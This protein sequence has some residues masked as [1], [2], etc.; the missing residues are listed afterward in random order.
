MI[1]AVQTYGNNKGEYQETNVPGTI[2]IAPGVRE[3]RDLTRSHEPDGLIPCSVQETSL[4]SVKWLRASRNDKEEGEEINLNGD[5]KK[6]EKSA[7][8]EG[9]QLTPLAPSAEKRSES[10]EFIKQSHPNLSDFEGLF[11]VIFQVFQEFSR[12]WETSRILSQEKS[13]SLNQDQVKSCSCRSTAMAVERPLGGR[14]LQ[15]YSCGFT[16]IAVATPSSL[17]NLQR[18]S[19]ETTAMV[20]DL[21][22]FLL[23]LGCFHGFNFGRRNIERS[24]REGGI[25][26]SFERKR[27]SKDTEEEAIRRS[28][29]AELDDIQ[30]LRKVSRQEYLKKREE[31]KL[32]ELRDDIEDE[33][34]L[35]EGVKLSEVKYRELR[36]KKEIYELVKKRSEEAD[37]VNEVW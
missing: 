2:P 17:R 28:N 22:S 8:G 24:K 23:G 3:G 6:L 20:V 31:N 32:E 1:I 27:C 18:S 36:Y 13:Q 4:T 34:Y 12:F 19:G 26:A 15:S 35:L 11:E 7:Y 9:N 25:R 37:N 10:K 21:W 33:Q 5:E 16:A 29:A 30:T 14:K